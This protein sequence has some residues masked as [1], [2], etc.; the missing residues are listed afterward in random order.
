MSHI[1]TRKQFARNLTSG[2]VLL[3][4]EVAVAFLL[5]PYVILKLGAATYGVWAL[6]VSVI[7]Y[8]GL[9]DVGIRGS[10]GRYINHYLALK[11]SRALGEVVGTANVVLTALAGLAF[12]ASFLIADRFEHIFPKTPPELL[13][14]I[15]FCLPLLVVGLWLSFV[16]SI[17]GNLLA[18]REALYLTNQFAL[19]TLVLRTVATVWALHQGLGIEALVLVTIG[20][21]VVSF[22][23]ALWAVFRIY[24]ED[25]PRMVLFSRSRLME[26]WRYGIAAFAGRSAATMANDSAPVI[27]MW[28]LGPEAVAVYSVAMTL[29]QYSRR[30]IDQAGGAIFASV[31]KAGAI[32]DFPGLRSIFLKYMDISFA[33]GSLVFI[34]MMVFSHSFLGLWVGSEY[35][36]GAIVVAILAFGYLIQGVAST[37]SLTLASL[38]R[39]NLTMMIGIGE[40]LACVI[41]TAALPGLFGLGLAGMA[42]GATLP[43][44]FTNCVLYPTLAVSSMGEELR[45]EMW[46]HI[47]SNLFLC[48]GVGVAFGAV[49]MLIPSQ[50]WVGLVAATTVVT[51]LH[52]LVLGSRY[53]VLGPVARLNSAVRG[54]IRRASGRHT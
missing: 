41:L 38:D 14:T 24:A 5:T 10:V 19:L 15:R 43:R 49:Y 26:I 18:A 6:M 34:G 50:N 30:V 33:I 20:S 54:W 51:L 46:R 36:S 13:E 47:R 17:L 42:M 31:M 2:W 44:L 23:I 53:E 28:V 35:Q 11:D 45:P 52:L 22:G 29:T 27:G 4:A 1:A 37:S 16:T 21:A 8:M 40:A 7:G 9:I 32:K 25:T 12:A 48:L 3:T 39:V